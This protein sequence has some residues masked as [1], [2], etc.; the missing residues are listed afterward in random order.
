MMGLAH[1][2]TA[3]LARGL[4]FA[5]ALDCQEQAA[6]GTTFRVSSADGSSILAHGLP[7]AEYLGT[8]SIRRPPRPRPG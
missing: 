6:G 5:Q 4:L 7:S 2:E 8:A 1:I 3:N